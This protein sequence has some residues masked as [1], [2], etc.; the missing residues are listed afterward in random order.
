MGG[1]HCVLSRIGGQEWP[2]KSSWAALVR[3]SPYIDAPSDA[4]MMEDERRDALFAGRCCTGGARL[5]ARTHS[6][7]SD[8]WVVPCPLSFVAGS[9]CASI[10]MRVLYAYCMAPH[11]PHCWPHG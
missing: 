3:E 1:E 11:V 6:S 8:A 7:G 5:G 2:S 4:A 9:L 10:G